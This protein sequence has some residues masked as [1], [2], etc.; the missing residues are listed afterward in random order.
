MGL[1][2]AG[3]GTVQAFR[4]GPVPAP[5]GARDDSAFLGSRLWH[6]IPEA[7]SQGTE[8]SACWA[9]AA[10]A[11]LPGESM[12]ELTVGAVTLQGLRCRTRQFPG[13]WTTNVSAA[14]Q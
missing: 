3:V 10:L 6:T 11:D 5:L 8:T 14:R 12:D 2:V 1:A 7:S 9:P 4:L 13:L